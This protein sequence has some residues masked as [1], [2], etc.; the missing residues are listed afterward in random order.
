MNFAQIPGQKD[1][2]SRLIRSVREERVSHA[3]IFAGSEGCG[4]FALAFAYAKYI[5]CENRTDTDS[6]GT[7]KSCVKY[8]KLIHPDLHFVFPVIKGKRSNEPV[9]DNYIDEWREMVR[10]SPYITLNGWL[11]SLETGN[12]QGMIYTAEAA[13]IIKKLSL[14]TFESD[15]KIMITWLPEKMNQT[16]SNKLLKLIEEPPDKTIFLLVSEEPDKL[17]P[18]ILSRCQLLK[19]PV[20]SQPEISNYLE[21]RGVSADKAADAARISMGNISRAIQLSEHEESSH[22]NLE[23]FKLLMRFAYKGDVLSLMNW[24]EEMAAADRESQKNFIVFSLR[25]FR[26]N[27]M[28]TLGQ[29]KNGIVFLSGEESDFSGKFHP[30]INNENIDRLA[31]EFNLAHAHMEANGNAKIIFL[32]LGLKVSKVIR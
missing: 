31:T 10:K 4:S 9:S 11:E 12:L 1:I 2:I 24:S 25:M 3:Q 18:T 13:E 23:R 20:F 5:N 32:D 6:C 16:T 29:A 7:C 14:K 27:L 21:G 30:F 28:L 22:A 19:I 26:E 17:L 15:Y 8:E